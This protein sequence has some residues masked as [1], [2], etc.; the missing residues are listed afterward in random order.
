MIHLDNSVRMSGDGE[1][2]EGVAVVPLVQFISIPADSLCML[3]QS[4]KR[5]VRLMVVEMAARVITT[6][7]P[8]D[9]VNA[10][11]NVINIAGKR[12]RK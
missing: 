1:S 7:M 6:I 4:A 2:E 5:R 3:H 8:A 10:S 12:H 9:G 11:P